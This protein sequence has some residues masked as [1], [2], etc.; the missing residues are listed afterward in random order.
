MFGIKTEKF[1]VPD[2]SGKLNLLDLAAYLDKS[3]LVLKYYYSL[4]NMGAEE[5]GIVDYNKQPLD[6]IV[7]SYKTP[8]NLVRRHID[9]M[10]K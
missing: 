9:K 2:V 8:F 10:Y 3:P 4:R 7:V 5:S 6:V 1:I